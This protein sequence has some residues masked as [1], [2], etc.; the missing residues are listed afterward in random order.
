MTCLFLMT[1]RLKP[2]AA[3]LPALFTLS[4]AGA[5][6]SAGVEGRQPLPS[7]TVYASRFEEKLADALPQTSIV[8]AA[9]IQK[10]GASNVSEVLSKVA[11]LPLKLN[12]DGSTNAVIDMKG[13]GDSASNNIVV[14]LDGVRLSE[15]EQTMARTSMIPVEAIDHI[16]ITKTGNSVLYG[17]GANGG[18]INIITRKN[19][20][21]LTVVSAG[22]ASYT[23]YQSGLYHSQALEDSELSLFA[24]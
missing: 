11:G 19:V 7:I 2:L 1:T 5:Q 16:E 14:L 3:L 10:S 15:H 22:L 20:G 9:E 23:G 6:Q 17:D 18:T 4:P 12:L 24:R 21:N 8:T 13:Y